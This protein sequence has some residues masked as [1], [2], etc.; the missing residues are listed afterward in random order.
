MLHEYILD[1]A[2]A[3]D[4]GVQLIILGFHKAK[5][6][7]KSYS[8]WTECDIVNWTPQSGFIFLPLITFNRLHLPWCRLI[9]AA[10]TCHI[11]AVWWGGSPVFMSSLFLSFFLFSHIWFPKSNIKWL[12]LLLV[13]R[14]VMAKICSHLDLSHFILQLHR[15][16]NHNI[17]V[18]IS[19]GYSS[20]V[21]TE[22]LIERAQLVG[23]R[24]WT[25][26]FLFRVGF[27]AD[28]T[29]DPA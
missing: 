26:R 3:H 22:K 13:G 1:I 14:I 9:W 4:Y 27:N 12:V 19:S 17:Q 23:K 2:R 11:K 20:V 5:G 18:D 10:N 25:A 28:L 16:K 15:C 21:Q 7:V 29:G 24:G 8:S 6:Q